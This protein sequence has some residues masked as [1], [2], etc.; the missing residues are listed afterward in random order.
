MDLSKALWAACKGSRKLRGDEEQ[1]R[2]STA[3]GS[4]GPSPQASQADRTK[5]WPLNGWDGKQGVTWDVLPEGP[6]ELGEGQVMLPAHLGAQG[7]D[8]NPEQATTKREH[9]VNSDI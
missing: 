1:P 3:L 4:V 6:D 9:K 2:G 7:T 8:P 5:L